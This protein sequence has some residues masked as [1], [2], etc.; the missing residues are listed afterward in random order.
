MLGYVKRL[1]TVADEMLRFSVPVTEYRK[2]FRFMVKNFTGGDIFVGLKES[3]AQSEM[4][5]IPAYCAQIVGDLVTNTVYV[6][7][8]TTSEKGVEVQCLNW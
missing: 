4:F 6:F 1:P 5:L 8:K 7:P 2:P 3:A